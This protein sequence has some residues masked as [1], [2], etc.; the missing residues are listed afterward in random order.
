MAAKGSA[1]LR[2]NVSVIKSD[3]LHYDQDTDMADAYGH[4]RIFNNGNS[5]IGPEAHLKVEANEGYMTNPKYRFNLSNGSGSAQRADLIDDE[6]TKV[7]HGTYTACSCETD[8]AWYIKGTSFD[9]DTGAN[10]GVAHNGVLFFQG[11]PVFASPW[12]SFPLTGE[13][14][15]GI[16]PPTVS[17]NSTTG[18]EVSLPYYF[19]I[20]PNRDLVVTPRLMTRR[21]IQ[22]QSTFRY[23]SP[24]YSGTITGEFLPQDLQTHTNRYA[25]YIQ[26]QQNFGGGF[27]AYIN[28]NKVS[29][30]QYPED[31]GNAANQI[32]NGTQVL[33]QQ[34]VGCHVQQRAVV[35]SRARAALASVAAGNLAVCPRTAVERAVQQVQRR[36]LRLRRGSGLHALHDHHRGLHGRPARCF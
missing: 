36:R 1:E 30:N 34:E 15:S 12:L 5:F 18:F 3:A 17:V 23:L 11:F 25:I 35:D 21:G 31:L 13:R 7:D 29:D 26:H 24:T 20:A 2:R 10:E 14:R 9:F 6:Q 19:N 22:I 27:G 8:P 16:L 28:Y 32:I 33:Y 4:V